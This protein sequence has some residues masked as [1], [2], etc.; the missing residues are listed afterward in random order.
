MAAFALVSPAV[1]VS[2]GEALVDLV[3]EPVPGGGPMNVAIAGAR[4]GVP[5]AFVGCV[6]TDEHGQRIWQHLESNGVELAACTR[7]DQPTAQAIVEHVPELR[8]RFVGEGTADTLLT[9][10]DLA[11]LGQPQMILHGGTLG[12]FR[13]QT[14]ETL[15]RLVES[16]DGLVS[17]DPNVRPQIIDDRDRWMHFHDRWLARTNIYK[18]SDEDLEW[19]WP[20][21]SAEDS[22]A[23]VLENGVDVVVLTR[24]AEGLSIFAGGEEH[25]ARAPEVEVV[26]TVGAGDTIVAALLAS[27]CDE[28]VFDAVA[29]GGLGADR[30]SKFADRA[31]RAAAITCSR[32]GADAPAR[33][34]L[35]W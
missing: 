32:A 23:A 16:H 29:L 35:D 21:R 30:W 13:G 25:T 27:L 10:V 17:L 33:S 22:A 15:A 26:D 8:F 6:S 7:S 3:P 14:A 24:G 12:L 11:L 1:I 5:S 34:D 9:S 19:I 4:L 20:G 2:C 28:G 31:V 18:G